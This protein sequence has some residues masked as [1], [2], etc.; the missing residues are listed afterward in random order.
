[1]DLNAIIISTLFAA[2]A[3]AGIIVGYLLSS[4]SY[5][6]SLFDHV[7]AMLLGV[8]IGGVAMGAAILLFLFAPI[9]LIGIAAG[10]FVVVKLMKARKTAKA[11]AEADVE[12]RRSS[13]Q[14]GVYKDSYG[15]NF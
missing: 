11:V 15:R 3:F 9:V 5:E 6:P 13:P 7:I 1:M 12:R 10:I 8:F 14:K 2:A 4:K